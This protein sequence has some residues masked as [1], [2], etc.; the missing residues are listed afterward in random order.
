MLAS[1][2]YCCDQVSLALLCY[3]AT[4]SSHQA[5]AASAGARPGSSGLVTT[6]ARVATN[7]LYLCISVSTELVL[8]SANY[9][10]D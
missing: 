1:A 6:L 10:D 8:T 3:P 5:R 9:S 4:I 7:P 2:N